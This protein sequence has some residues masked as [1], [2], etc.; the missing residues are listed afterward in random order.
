MININENELKTLVE[1]NLKD[2]IKPDSY[3]PFSGYKVRVT[4]RNVKPNGVVSLNLGSCRLVEAMKMH[5]YLE[6]ELKKRVKQ[7]KTINTCC[8]EV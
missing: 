2:L 1:T 3:Y 7:I 4:V 5:N 6:K 8:S